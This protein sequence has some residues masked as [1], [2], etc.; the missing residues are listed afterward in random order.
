MSFY[1][2]FSARA[3]MR[4]Q[5]KSLTLREKVLSMFLMTLN[6]KLA[7]RHFEEFSKHS[8]AMEGQSLWIL[9]ESKG[10]ASMGS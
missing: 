3:A 4:L 8:P 10:A 5:G 9:R 2:D 6:E 7:A 1:D